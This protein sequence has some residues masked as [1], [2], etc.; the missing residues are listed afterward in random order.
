LA[1]GTGATAVVAG[2]FNTP[3]DSGV[4]GDFWASFGNAFSEAGFG[5]GNTHFTHRTSLRIDHVLFG[6][7]WRCRK[8]WVGPAVGSAHRPVI[9][10]LEPVTTSD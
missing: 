9:A 3:P 4:Y 8:C 10:D 5:F 7:G 2:D 1:A 6:R